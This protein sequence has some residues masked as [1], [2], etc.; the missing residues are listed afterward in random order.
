MFTLK[1]VRDEEIDEKK[2][3]KKE[4]EKDKKKKWETKKKEMLPTCG[5]R[6]ITGVIDTGRR[7]NGGRYPGNTPIA[8]PDEDTPPDCSP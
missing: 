4:D 1:Q 8:P 2:R 6:A 5:L 7:T 3:R